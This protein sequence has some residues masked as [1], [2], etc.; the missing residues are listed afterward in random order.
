[1]MRDR[2]GMTLLEL[3]LVLALLGVLTSLTALR[4]HRQ[5]AITHTTPEQEA[6]NRA[7]TRAIASGR[8]TTILIPVDE[9]LLPV[10]VR[11]DGVVIASP[12]LR[13]PVRRA[14]DVR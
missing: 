3:L 14:A 7:R 8:T 11:P 12:P 2:D 9:R 5:P 1:M 6:V 4:W 13:P 10:T